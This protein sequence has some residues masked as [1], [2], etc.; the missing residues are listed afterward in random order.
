MA[1]HGVLVSSFVGALSLLSG[2]VLLPIV[3]NSVGYGPYGVWIFLIALTTYVGYG[4]LGVYAAIVHFGSQTRASTGPYSMSQLMTA[5]VLWSVLVALVVVPLYGWLAWL[6]VVAQ[7]EQ[8]GLTDGTIAILV[9]LGAAVA[10][11][12]VTRPFGGAMVGS[13]YLML[14][15]RAQ[16]VALVF[17]VVGTLVAA[18]GFK[19]IVAVAVVETIATALPSTMI[20]PYVLTRVAPLRF[21]RDAL[22]P[23]G[24][25]LGYSVKS[26]LT[27]LPL[28]VITSGGT[29]ILG[30]LHGPVQ[31]TYFTFAFRVSAGLRTALAWLLE[32]FRSAL[33]RIA[34]EDRQ[35]HLNRDLSLG[36]AAA[37]II[38]AAAGFLGVSA[39]WL[40]GLWVGHDAPAE[41]IAPTAVVLLVGLVLES[42]V[43]PLVLAG[44]T[45][46]RP[47]LFVVPQ[48]AWAVG[49]V[50]LGIW[51]SSLWSSVGMS[52]AIVVPLLL[53][54]PWYFKIARDQIGFPVGRWGR[55]VARPS[56]ALVLPPL[57]LG[58]VALW[59]AGAAAPWVGG[60][61][62]A[63]AGL[64]NLALLRRHLPLA[65]LSETVRVRM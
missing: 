29:I 48:A 21:T 27:S 23:L 52:F 22:R 17:R 33:S 45:V 7:A 57:A 14:D 24:M 43:M 41:V 59:L 12:A 53:V 50:A 64:G 44:D 58:L 47:G 38:G 61:V 65:Q 5:G 18:L 30:L 15:K 1:F 26:L 31:V 6:F 42:L 19:S 46:G 60:L 8:Q 36:F 55:E 39:Y 2:I 9:A 28:T 63:L 4:D 51:W 32:P 25:M 35:V 40:I 10:G 13:G 3:A 56:V 16:F 49:F 37:S 20:I 11:L 54:S 34:A 62:F